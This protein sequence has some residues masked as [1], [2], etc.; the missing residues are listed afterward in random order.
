MDNGRLFIIG[1]YVDMLFASE[2]AHHASDI[3]AAL[4]GNTP[5]FSLRS[6]VLK[7]PGP[8]SSST[9]GR[10]LQPAALNGRTMTFD[11]SSHSKAK[12]R[13]GFV[14]RATGARAWLTLARKSCQSIS[15]AQDGR[16]GGWWGQA[17]AAVDAVDKGG[18]GRGGLLGGGVAMGRS[19]SS[20]EKQKSSA[21]VDNGGAVLVVQTL[22]EN[23]VA[24]SLKERM[25]YVWQRMRGMQRWHS[26]QQE[27]EIVESLAMLKMV[28]YS[29]STLSGWVVAA[30]PVT[31]F[32]RKGSTPIHAFKL[33]Q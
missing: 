10:L 23:R 19:S 4:L 11:A 6:F 24:K 25:K 28:R 33:E 27:Q 9:A 16:R 30:T 15:G 14:E 17:D 7:L 13:G 22:K 8:H 21:G 26:K 20:D 29:H 12:A 5:S 2:A 32:Q 3:E 1:R 18:Y 31:A